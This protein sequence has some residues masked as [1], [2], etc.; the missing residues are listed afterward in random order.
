MRTM[1]LSSTCVA[2]ILA[3]SALF[4]GEES[5]ALDKL[6]KAVL[7]AVKKRFPKAEIVEAAKETEGDKVEFEVSIK[8]GEAKIDVTLT[9]EGKITLIEKEIAAKD[10]PKAIT[11][12]LN[13]KYEKATFKTVEEITKVADGKEAVDYYEVLLVTADKK[14]L[15][16][17]VTLDG[18]IKN[19]EEKK[20]EKEEKK[21][22][23][24]KE[25]KKEDKK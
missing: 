11:E 20:E 19:V 1:L 15:E 16:V 25:E 21:K 17:Q 13:T 6:P 22:E 4:A 3:T 7:E 9:P 12:A 8:D 14:T 5:I 10:L 23:N 2:V 24:K 18:K